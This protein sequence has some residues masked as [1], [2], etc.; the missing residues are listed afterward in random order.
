VTL[1]GPRGIHCRVWHRRE[2][3]MIVSEWCREI[4]YLGAS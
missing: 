4:Y 1:S 3:A 2:R